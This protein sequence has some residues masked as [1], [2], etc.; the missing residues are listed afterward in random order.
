MWMQLS[1]L[2]LWSSS[3]KKKKKKEERKLISRV[4]TSHY[5]KYPIPQIRSNQIHITVP[6][7]NSFI[8]DIWNI[9][10]RFWTS[11]IW[12]RKQIHSIITHLPQQLPNFLFHYLKS[13][14]QFNLARNSQMRSTIMV[15]RNEC[16]KWEKQNITSMFLK[17]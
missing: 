2:R 7:Q 1:L 9:H 14:R 17:V 5:F 11:K 3:K 4:S 8:E 16:S 12:G 10:L 15:K 6:L 13:L